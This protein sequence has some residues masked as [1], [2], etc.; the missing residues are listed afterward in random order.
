ML[1][2]YI[3]LADNPIEKNEMLEAVYRNEALSGGTNIL[4]V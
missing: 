4:M 1:V 2:F 3:R